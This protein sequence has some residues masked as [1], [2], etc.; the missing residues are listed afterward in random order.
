MN[1]IISV[2][3]LALL[4]TT[5]A[6]KLRDSDNLFEDDEDTKETLKSI[7]TAEKAHNYKFNGISKEEEKVLIN[8]KNMLSFDESEN[9]VGMKPK[10][11]EFLELDQQMNYPEA[12]PIGEILMQFEDDV[13]ANTNIND[14]DDMRDTL[15]SIAQAER[16]MGREMNAPKSDEKFYEIHGNKYENLLA[17]NSRVYMNE[18]EEAE[19][20]KEDIAKLARVEQKKIAVVQKKV[21]MKK[22]EETTKEQRAFDAISIH[23]HDDA[24]AIN[25]EEW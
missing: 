25:G 15:D 22:K 16:S 18:I 12:R 9:F 17:D 7:E 2:A 1:K 3:V 13:F 20:D 21:E 4:G 6:I 11:Y 24:D 10:K 19:K 14:E 5:A 8:S 23:F